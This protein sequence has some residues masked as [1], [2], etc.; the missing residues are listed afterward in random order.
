MD[1]SHLQLR[2]SS[3]QGCRMLEGRGAGLFR[4]FLTILQEH[5]QVL[6]TLTNLTGFL[7]GFPLKGQL[8][9]IPHSLYYGPL[10][11]QSWYTWHEKISSISSDGYLAP[12]PGTDVPFQMRFLTYRVTEW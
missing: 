3:S 6:A 11:A 9:G 7:T 2:K 1:G 4:E 5:H 10:T 8:R 12:L